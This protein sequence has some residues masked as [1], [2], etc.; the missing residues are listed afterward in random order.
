V[1]QDPSGL[2]V[3]I[4][5]LEP[6]C[7]DSGVRRAV[8]RG[9][10]F[11]V[12]RA[13]WWA[14]LTGKLGAHREALKLLLR[15]RRAFAKPLKGKLML[16][17]V[18]GFGA[19]LLGSAEA[20][21][22]GSRI[23]THCLVGLFVIPV[24]PLG[25]YVVV[26]GQRKGLSTSWNI[27]A[28]VPLGVVAWG[29]SRALALAV[30]VAVAWAGARAV[31]AS[32][33][34]ELTVVN[35]L[36]APLRVAVG[37][38]GADVP[39]QQRVQ[40]DL[41]TGTWSARATLGDG[42]EVDALQL[43]VVA[44]NSIDLWNV[45]GAAP[46][47]VETVAYTKQPTPEAKVPDPTVYCGDRHFSL[48]AIDDAFTDPPQKIS[49]DKGVAR[50]L[51]RH[52]DVAR[53]P[54]ADGVQLCALR[55]LGQK[56]LPEAS[57]LAELRARASGWERDQASF[58]VALALLGGQAELARV[59]RAYR[60]ARPGEVDAARTYEWALD[61]DEAAHRALVTEFGQAAG[62]APDDPKA[63]YLQV[64]LLEG[65][66][67]RRAAEG[68]LLRFPK[69]PDLLRFAV[70]QRAEDG[71]F[72]GAVQAY[73]AL[74]AVAPPETGRVLGEVATALVAQGLGEEAQRELA[75]A[76][77][78][79]KGQP[80]IE[81]AV[82]HV[83]A[84][85]LPSHQPDERLVKKW[86]E[87]LGGE[88]PNLG[89]RVRCGLPVPAE[90]LQGGDAVYAA[91]RRDPGEALRLAA[92]LA[93]L[94]IL[95]LDVDAWALA[96]LEAVRAGDGVAARLAANNHQ[97]VRQRPDLLRWVRGEGGALPASLNLE[98]RAAA[99][100][101][102]SRNPGLDPA[103]RKALLAAARADDR[104]GGLVTQAMA[105]WPAATR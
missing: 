56:Q 11:A 94:D 88:Q 35:G 80:R 22:D 41:P 97:G 10:P 50:V 18:N 93:P 30:L 102:R 42:T 25:A 67:G 13:L 48:A 66:E 36:A 3:R 39:A 58:A 49:M 16:G 20:E 91:L 19:T 51:R 43:K 84:A 53:P 29:F 95:Q 34:H 24:F 64:R 99:R 78:R 9:D 7:E 32:G 31:R 52:L 96:Y 17:T 6:L 46:V 54:Q 79:L 61:V 1:I 33:R 47:F 98:T 55:L 28:R 105:A 40:L 38:I 44:G 92:G 103:E 72:P 14:R 100:F 59:A 26:G 27:F 65:A 2:L 82:L 21:P 90:G 77:G 63:L 62:A 57:R 68:A 5:E 81:A 73:R 83:R 37:T 69:D 71:D 12:Y 8:G 86:E 70:A 15:S 85:A 89:L 23:A 45:A 60:A 74:A 76:V 87:V 4:Q 104:L 101:I 75:D